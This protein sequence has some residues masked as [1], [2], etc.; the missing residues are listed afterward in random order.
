MLTKFSITTSTSVNNSNVISLYDFLIYHTKVKE[1]CVIRLKGYIQYI[2]QID[3]EDTFIHS[4][5]NDILHNYVVE[6]DEWSEI[7]LIDENEKVSSVPCH[8]INITRFLL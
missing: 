5:P 7:C 2:V 3:H 8:N 1:L 6:S 4:I